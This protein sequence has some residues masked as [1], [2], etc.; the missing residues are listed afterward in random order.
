MDAHSEHALLG[1]VHVAAVYYVERVECDALANRLSFQLSANGFP[2]FSLL[3]L[4]GQKK[5]RPVAI[6]YYLGE[7]SWPSPVSSGPLR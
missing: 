4:A 1:V 3:E 2:H 5:K 6:E 7:Y